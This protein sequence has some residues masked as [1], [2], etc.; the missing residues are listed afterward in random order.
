MAKN[1][2][3]AL[4][5]R[6]NVGKSRLFN[7]LA[8]S[9]LSIVH[10]RPGVTRDVV[11]ADLQNG[12]T[13]LDTGGLGLRGGETPEELVRAVESQVSMAMSMADLFVFVVDGRVGPTAQDFEIADK[14]R[15]TGKRV[16][17][18]INKIDLES[19]E[20]AVDDWSQLGFTDSQVV[21]SAEHGRGIDFLESSIYGDLLGVEAEVET[22]KPTTLALV[23]APNVGKSSIANGLLG[24][25]RSIVSAVAGT[26][27]DTIHGHFTFT[28]D[29]NIHPMRLLDTAGLRATKKISSPVEYFSSLRARRAMDEADVLFLVLDAARG[30][31]SFDK[32]V[33]TAAAEA[34]KCLAIAVNK[35]DLAQDAIRRDELPAYEDCD[36]FR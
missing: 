29:G 19:M 5:G 31:T 22:K 6:P 25:N 7:R 34:K 15:K 32:S 2:C 9:R 14:L 13:L 8:R 27:R 24:E 10:D 28:K 4:V 36:T 1:F 23:G 20:L 12:V 33:A 11:S 35:W 16:V 17:L 18:A 30:L 3:I 26:T 21:I